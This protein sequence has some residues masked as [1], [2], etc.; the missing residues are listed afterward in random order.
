MFDL[1]TSQDMEHEFLY[2]DHITL[3]ACCARTIAFDETMR[4]INPPNTVP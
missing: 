4:H 2:H 1:V 3:A